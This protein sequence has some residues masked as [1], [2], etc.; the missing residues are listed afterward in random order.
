MSST[1]HGGEVC[2]C[3]SS[4]ELLSQLQMHTTHKICM[5][6]TI[7]RTFVIQLMA[8]STSSRHNGIWWALQRLRLSAVKGRLNLP[9]VTLFS[10]SVKKNKKKEKRGRGERKREKSREGARPTRECGGVQALDYQLMYSA[11]SSRED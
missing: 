2:V 5:V 10:L 7:C 11:F 6:N 3:V 8:S 9:G 1:T 4:L